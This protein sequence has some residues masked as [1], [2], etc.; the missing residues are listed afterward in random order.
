MVEMVD[1]FCKSGTFSRMLP[2]HLLFQRIPE[3]LSSAIVR[4]LRSEEREVYKSTLSAL[5]T[6]RRLRP[7]FIQR[8]LRTRASNS[9][10]V[11]IGMNSCAISAQTGN[12]PNP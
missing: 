9:M 5:A 1:L 11:A 2:S 12:R 6:E 3:E 10:F 7:V 4:Y 8:M